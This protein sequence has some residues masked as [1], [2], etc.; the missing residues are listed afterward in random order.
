MILCHRNCVGNE[1]KQETLEP[2]K[3]ERKKERLNFHSNLF[4]D[5]ATVVQWLTC[6][7]AKK[8]T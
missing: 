2:L 8:D 1:T 7:R 3:K 4:P 5:L 6:Q